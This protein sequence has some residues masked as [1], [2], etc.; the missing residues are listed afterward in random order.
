LCGAAP[1]AD[2]RAPLWIEDD[3]GTVA[4]RVEVEFAP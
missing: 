3:A 1:G 2:G 4:L